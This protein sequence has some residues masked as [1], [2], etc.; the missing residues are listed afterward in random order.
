MFEKLSIIST[1]EF[2]EF[3]Q[4]PTSSFEFLLFQTHSCKFFPQQINVYIVLISFTYCQ[5]PFMEFQ[6]FIR[7]L[8][9]TNKKNLHKNSSFLDN[10]NDSYL[11]FTGLL[12]FLYFF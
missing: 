12:C 3:F 2:V 6:I 8:G 4:F 10:F 11:V 9:E 1:L 5:F 7:P